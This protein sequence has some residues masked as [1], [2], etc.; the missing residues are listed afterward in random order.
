M[1]DALWYSFNLM[2]TA[3]LVAQTVLRLPIYQYGRVQIPPLFFIFSSNIIYFY[4]HNKM[5]F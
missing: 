4:S 1:M 5:R 2:P 3:E